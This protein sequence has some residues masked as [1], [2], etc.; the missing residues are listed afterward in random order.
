MEKMFGGLFEFSNKN[1]IELFLKDIDYENSIRIVEMGLE[2]A[3]GNGVY[4][5]EETHLLYNCILKLKK[6]IYETN[7]NISTDSGNGSSDN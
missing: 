3:H 7:S 1:D 5:M 2:F 6:S 4:S